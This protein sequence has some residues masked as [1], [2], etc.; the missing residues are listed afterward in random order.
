MMVK[1]TR[2]LLLFAV[3][4][5]FNSCSSDDDN[6]VVDSTTQAPVQK[7][8]YNYTYTSLE[9]ETLALVNSYRVSIGLNS[10][11]KDNFISLK[12]EE[13]NSYMINSK[14]ASHNNFNTR[15]QSIVETL[16]A[17]KLGENI[18][19]NYYSSKNMLDAWLKSTLH[20]E[21][22]EGDYTHFGI[23]IRLSPEGNI[24]C[25]NIFA[26]IEKK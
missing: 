15:Y 17:I 23:S 12:S 10:L 14:V 3:A 5:F 24:Y 20:K 11:E 26:K 6:S 25:T 21:C 4:Y 2:L 16:G 19:Y 22:L 13:H 1:I 7:T 9:D 18:A 8:I